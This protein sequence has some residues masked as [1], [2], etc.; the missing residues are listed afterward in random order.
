MMK[1]RTTGAVTRIDVTES[2]GNPNSNGHS[3]VLTRDDGWIVFVSFASNLV[4]GDTNNKTDVFVR[5]RP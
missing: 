1:N 4:T 2:G 5:P 3:P